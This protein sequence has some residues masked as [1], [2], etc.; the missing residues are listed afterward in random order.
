[1]IKFFN[2]GTPVEYGV[3][4]IGGGLWLFSSAIAVFIRKKTWKTLE[5]QPHI[6]YLSDAD[7]TGF[8]VS[9]A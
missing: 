1:M 3:M 5:L 7:K 4:G 8:V 9:H 2:G 6:A